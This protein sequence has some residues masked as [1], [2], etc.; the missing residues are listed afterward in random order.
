M[1]TDT[2]QL[3]TLPEDHTC[4]NKYSSI[5]HIA[6]DMARL[7][8]AGNLENLYQYVLIPAFWYMTIKYNPNS[9]LG[10]W[11]TNSIELAARV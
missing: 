11:T 8:K 1:V 7:G 9:F 6:S 5:R 10:I 3:E 2:A 4:G